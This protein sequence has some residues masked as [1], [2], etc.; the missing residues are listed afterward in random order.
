[1]LTCIPVKM[2]GRK[3][4][5]RALIDAEDFE[6][7]NSYKWFEVK[8]GYA[9]HGPLLMHRLIMNAKKGQLVDHRDE[10]KLNNQ[11][12]NLRFCSD[13]ENRANQSKARKNSVSGL[14]G[15]Y[16]NKRRGKWMSM[17]R[18]DGRA[19]FLGHYGTKEE[20]HEAYKEASRRFYGEFS[21]Y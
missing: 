6:L 20:A 11:K 15:T 1:M 7:V 2:L 5:R 10:D 3:A 9:G 21:P 4:S 12:A 14:R 8:G 17:I 18:K 19:Y 16:F 13:K